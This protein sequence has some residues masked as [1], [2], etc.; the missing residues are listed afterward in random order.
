MVRWVC[1]SFG[2]WRYLLAIIAIKDKQVVGS[3]YIRFCI[4]I[5]ILNLL[6]SQLII[7]LAIIAYSNYLVNNLEKEGF[8]PIFTDQVV[9]KNNTQPFHHTCNLTKRWR[10]TSKLTHT[11]LTIKN[12]R[13][14]NFQ[15]LILTAQRARGGFICRLTPFSPAENSS[16]GWSQLISEARIG[17]PKTTKHRLFLGFSSIESKSLIIQGAQVLFY[18]SFSQIFLRKRRTTFSGF[19]ASKSLT[20]TFFQQFFLLLIEK[21]I[22]IIVFLPSFSTTFQ[23]NFPKSSLVGLVRKKDIEGQ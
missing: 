4:S 3:L 10:R 13:F 12:N 16:Q 23:S 19:S 18:I 2:V 20:S 15:D 17:T 1:V 21:K 5:K 7:S 6:I 8:Y 9:F 14:P 11:H 22:T